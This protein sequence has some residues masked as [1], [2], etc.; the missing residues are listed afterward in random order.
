[1]QFEEKTLKRQDIFEGKIFK[2][3]VDQVALPNDKG[4][5]TR[6]LIF[7][8]GAV[9]ILAVTPENKIII[10]KQYRKA[11]EKVSYEIPAG[12]LEVGENGS[13]K[14][15]ALRE[16]E[17]ETG[18]TGDLELIHSF[19]TAI[20]FCNEKI[21][22][23]LAKDLQRVE[24]PRPQDDDETLAVYEFSYEECQDL[25]ASGQ[26]EDAKTIIALQYYAL[27]FGGEK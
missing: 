21:Q 15:A 24:N 12:K 26:I 2:V 4:T 18:Y 6:E 10:V 7:H 3:A 1:M 9:S 19:Y 22:L 8:R 27:H 23:Y 17:E 5:A 25:V 14:E 11:I 13:E 16:L 20:G